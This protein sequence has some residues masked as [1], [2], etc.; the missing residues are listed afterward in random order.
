MSRL[1]VMQAL[2][3]PEDRE[4]PERLRDHPLGLKRAGETKRAALRGEEEGRDL[5]IF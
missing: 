4:A 5:T 2:E 1:G 3:G